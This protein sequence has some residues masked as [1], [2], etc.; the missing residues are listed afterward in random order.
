MRPSTSICSSIQ[1][2]DIVPVK[3]PRSIPNQR[4]GL[5]QNKRVRS[6][7]YRTPHPRKGQCLVATT[8][9]ATTA[10]AVFTTRSATTTTAATTGTFFLRASDV[11]GKGP[12][13]QC[14]SVHR[15]DGLLCLFGRRH[16]DE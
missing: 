4:A 12:I 7:C 9:A 5:Q 10:A 1:C 11:H 16:G 13:V 14:G 8:A 15:L 2:V 6:Q 3:P